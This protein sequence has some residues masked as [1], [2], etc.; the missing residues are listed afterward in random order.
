MVCDHGGQNWYVIFK[1]FSFCQ[2][3][4]F[5]QSCQFRLCVSLWCPLC[6]VLCVQ[7]LLCLDLNVQSVNEMCTVNMKCA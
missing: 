6:A 3:C 1:S 7:Y 5:C 2:F 4:Q